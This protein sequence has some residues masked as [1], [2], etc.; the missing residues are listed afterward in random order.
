MLDGLLDFTWIQTLIALLV[1]THITIAAVL[2]SG[3]RP[4][5]AAVLGARVCLP[6]PGKARHGE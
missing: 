2:G 6:P 3:R 1:M 4:H 5:I